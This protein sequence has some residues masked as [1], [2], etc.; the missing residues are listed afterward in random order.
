MTAERRAPSQEEGAAVLK[1][2]DVLAALDDALEEHERWMSRWRRALVCRIPPDP[3]LLQ[4]D[5]H[6]AT[7]FG[8]WYTI[9]ADDPLLQ[10]P[11]LGDL[12]R[13]YLEVHSLSRVLAE[14]ATDAKPVPVGEYDELVRR[15][16][17][18]RSRARRL[19]DAFRKAVSELDPLTGLSTRAAMAAELE[20]EYARAAGGGSATGRGLAIALADIDRFKQVNDVHGHAVGDEVLRAVAGRFLSRLRPSDSI[21]RYGGEEFLVSLPNA[22]PGVARSVLER[23]REALEE[24]PVGLENGEE[25]HVTASFGVA[26]AAPGVGLKTVIERADEAL[27]EAKRG[28]RNRVVGWRADEPGRDKIYDGGDDGE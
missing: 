15:E 27:Y 26:A 22:S 4:E 24:R 23:L 5:Q 9:H 21:Y 1:A 28:G 13:C 16:D 8:R 7:E 17:E 11:A 14:R 20:A 2:G 18:F 6:L 19:R 25:L 12:W 10:Q 3:D